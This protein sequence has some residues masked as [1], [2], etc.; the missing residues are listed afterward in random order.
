MRS[1]SAKPLFAISRKLL[2]SMLLVGL[3]YYAGARLG[4]IL[5]DPVDRITLVWPATGIAVAA[6]LRLGWRI[7]PGIFLAVVLAERAAEHSWGASLGI[8]CTNTLGPLTAFWLMKGLRFDPGFTRAK[9]GPILAFSAVLGMTVTAAGGALGL[10]LGERIPWEAFSAAWTRWWLGDSGGV[11]LMAPLLISL[12]RENLSG[13]RRRPAEFTLLCL[14]IAIGGWLIFFAPGAAGEVPHLQ[15][16]T[17]LPLVAWGAMRFGSLGA[18]FSTLAISIVAAGASALGKG[19]FHLPDAQQGTLLLWSFIVTSSLLGLMIT[20]MQ[21]QR[22]WS[23]RR[24]L[25][26]IDTAPNVAV[27]WCDRKGI[28][29]YWN[30]T[31][32]SLFGWSE[33]EALGRD[34]SRLVGW[35]DP[36]GMPE[37]L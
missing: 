17:I 35:Q 32:E 33:E 1:Y 16:F 23:E 25:A 21:T 15:A 7:T 29:R 8:A 31:S 19:Q 20:A 3:A 36:D 9:D 18:G 6:L 12:T 13:I 24:L 14:G 30:R 37:G 34:A 11:L 22:L 26:L 5:S 2:L 28:V 10:V 27:R 4:L